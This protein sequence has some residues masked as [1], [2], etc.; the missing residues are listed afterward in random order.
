MGRAAKLL[1]QRSLPHHS[2]LPVADAWRARVWRGRSNVGSYDAAVRARIGWWMAWWLA[3]LGLWLLLVSVNTAEFV[4][5]LGAAAAAATAAEV[6][7]TQGLVRFDPDPR[8]V[9]RIWR[10]PRSI[11]RDCWVLTRALAQHLRGK[12]VNSGFRAIPFRSGGDDARAS[13]RRALV[14]PAISVSPNTYVIGIDEEADLMLVH[15]LV[16]APK[17]TAEREIY[18]DL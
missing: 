8:W 3:L 9:L 6:V 7:R 17:N 13:A 15:Q 1:G 2:L 5:G 4:A 18:A 12:P 14:V 10:V 11:L 16:A